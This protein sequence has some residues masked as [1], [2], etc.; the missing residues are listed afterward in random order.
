MD[1][2]L[3]NKYQQKKGAPHEQAAKVDE[4]VKIVGLS[5]EYPYTYWLRKVKNFSYGYVLEICKEADSLDKKY[6]KGG[7]LT[8][9]LCKKKLLKLTQK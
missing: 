9:K 3:F 6:S 7:Y 1:T 4:I 5:K 8:N 2:L